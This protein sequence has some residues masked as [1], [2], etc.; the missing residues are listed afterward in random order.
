ML[1]AAAAQCLIVRRG[2]DGAVGARDRDPEPS[3]VH[4][5]AT[6]DRDELESPVDDALSTAPIPNTIARPVPVT[7]R[8]A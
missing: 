7:A 8:L 1:L 2:R 6:A 4:L 5:R 3:A